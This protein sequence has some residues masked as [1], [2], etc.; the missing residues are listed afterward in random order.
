M[1]K[2]NKNR[3]HNQNGVVNNIPNNIL[4]PVQNSSTYT[5]Q[6]TLTI[7]MSFVPTQEY[8]DLKQENIN[9]KLQILTM[10]GNS[11]RLNETIKIN[12]I[13]L[14]ELRSENKKLRDEISR[15]TSD[16]DMLK[17][18]IKRLEDKELTSKLKL[19]IQD[20]NSL[21]GLQNKNSIYS[22][23]ISKIRVSRNND[24]HY[25]N[26]DDDIDLVSCKEQLILQYL[27]NFPIEIVN[28]FEKK[29]K[30]NGLISYLYSQIPRI[31]MSKFSNDKIEEAS[32]WW[33]E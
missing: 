31:D 5:Q 18:K 28:S 20:L 21:Y 25:I 33:E 14:E 17:S 6:M 10:T 7:P 27:E 1:S 19:V 8:M 26:I 23:I 4:N 3:K 11:D 24:C 2:I 15:L 9:L 30:A 32:E 22:K 12:N 13:E 29:N 16:V